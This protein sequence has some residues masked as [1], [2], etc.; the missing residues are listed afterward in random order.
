MT[1]VI[2]VG[3]GLLLLDAGHQI[4]TIGVDVVL[5]CLRGLDMESLQSFV[6]RWRRFGQDNLP[7][8]V[9]DLQHNGSEGTQGLLGGDQ[10][11]T[12]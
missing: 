2:A 9:L 12:G 5:D 8:T 11:K 6:V 1:V 3:L 4:K 7:G 10:R